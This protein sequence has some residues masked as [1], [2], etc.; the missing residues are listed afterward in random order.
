[1]NT[2]V[3]LVDPS[4]IV[5]LYVLNSWFPIFIIHISC[6]GKSS[7]FLYTVIISY[8]NI[9][10]VLRSKYYTKTT[11]SVFYSGYKVLHEIHVYWNWYKVNIDIK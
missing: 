4:L 3:F 2:E 1:M 7:M 6:V 9:I 5:R 11:L 10:P 8:R